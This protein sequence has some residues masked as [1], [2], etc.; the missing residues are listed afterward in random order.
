M[1]RIVVRQLYNLQNDPPISLILTWHHTQILQYYWLYSQ[2]RNLYPYDYFVTTHLYFSIP[3]PFSP[4]P[5][6][7]LPSGNHQSVLCVLKSAS[8]LFVHLYC[9]LD[10]TYKWNHMV[11][12][13]LTD[14]FHIIPARS[15]HDVTKGKISF[16]LLLSNIPL[17]TC[18]TTFYP[19]AYWWAL[20]LLP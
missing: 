16:F 13:F 15:I 7:S 12:V 2:C 3:S 17:Y 10:S 20:G 6:N 18:S 19:L 5:P 9:S 4:S 11:F 14:L 8:V 1:Y